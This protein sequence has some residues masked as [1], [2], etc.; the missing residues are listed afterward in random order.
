M[1]RITLLMKPELKNE[2]Q[3]LADIETEGRLNQFVR[4]LIGEALAMRKFP[5]RYV[6]G[7][8]PAGEINLDSR[9]T[10]EMPRLAHGYD[11]L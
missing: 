9:A 5:Q 8:P 2:L 1:L 3:I 7:V 4:K 11:A 10:I 6:V